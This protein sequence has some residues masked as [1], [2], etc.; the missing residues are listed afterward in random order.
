MD[1][2]TLGQYGEKIAQTYLENRGYTFIQ[3]NFHAQGGEIDLIMKSPQDEW[4]F[5]EVKTRRSNHFGSPK[6]AITNQKIQRMLRAIEAFFQQQS[7]S[8]IPE[9]HLEAI[10]LRMEQKK[11]FCEHLQNISPY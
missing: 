5:I 10:C 8:E 7:L 6:D 1:R 2:Q 9:F 4:T 11:V 3:A